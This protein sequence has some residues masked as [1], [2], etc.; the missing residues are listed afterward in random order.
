MGVGLSSGAAGL[1]T[2]AWWKERHSRGE[3]RPWGLGVL[4]VRDSKLVAAIRSRLGLEFGL[5]GVLL[6]G[7]PAWAEMGLG[8]KHWAKEEKRPKNKIK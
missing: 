3:G 7:R 6:L 5:L 2:W 8:S 4:D 1:R